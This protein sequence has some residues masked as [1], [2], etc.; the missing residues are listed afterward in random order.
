MREYKNNPAS[1]Q[2]K[3]IFLDIDGVLNGYSRRTLFIYKIAKLLKLTKYYKRLYDPFSIHRRKFKL[4]AKAVRRTHSAVVLS[5]TWRYKWSDATCTDVRI[6][7]LRNLINLYD[8]PILGI[9]S[10]D[11]NLSRQEAI[12]QWLSEHSINRFCI[13]DDECSQLNETFPNKCVSTSSNNTLYSGLRR[14][15]INQIVKILEVI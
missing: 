1:T 14:K 12:Q 5:S 2:T 4:L 8:V 9:T 3:V 10:L 6:T 13:I 7:E 11:R 15:H